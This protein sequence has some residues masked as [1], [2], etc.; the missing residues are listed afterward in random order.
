MRRAA[1]GAV[2]QAKE[3]RGLGVGVRDAL[4]IG[5]EV[6]VEPVSRQEGGRTGGGVRSG[7]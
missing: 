4:G 3:I 2:W 1:R 6:E 5:G 7:A